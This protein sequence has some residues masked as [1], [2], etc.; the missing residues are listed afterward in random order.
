MRVIK[1]N[2]KGV[3]KI[4]LES[5]S[6]HRGKYTETYNEDAYKQAGIDVNFIQD[7]ISFSKKNVLR[8]LHFQIKKYLTN[9]K[10]SNLVFGT[11]ANKEVREPCFTPRLN[12]F[13]KIRLLAINKSIKKLSLS[14]KLVA[15]LRFNKN[16]NI[17]EKS[18][19]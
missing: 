8:G 13:Q 5:F 2:L 4:E 9:L 18:K 15:K 11:F 17:S 7:D 19:K 10:R 16:L 3:M 1:T 14:L 12:K 6:D